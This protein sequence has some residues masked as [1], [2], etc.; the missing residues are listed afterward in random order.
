[1]NN[2]W[3]R[4]FVN[5]LRPTKRIRLISFSGTYDSYLCFIFDIKA[6]NLNPLSRLDKTEEA[7]K[8]F[9]GG[10]K[11][12]KDLNIETEEVIKLRKQVDNINRMHIA[13]LE[14]QIKIMQSQ[15]EKVKESILTPKEKEILRLKKIERELEQHVHDWVTKH[16]DHHGRILRRNLL[17][18]YLKYR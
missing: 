4:S 12:L 18:Y 13:T 17:L 6:F 14:Q 2:Y 7:R 11:L 9:L 16:K 15:L 1:M 8:T 5:C 3:S 10:H